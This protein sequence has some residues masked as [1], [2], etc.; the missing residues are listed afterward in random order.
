MTQAVLEKARKS[1]G[2]DQRVGTVFPLAY[3][4]ERLVQKDKGRLRSGRCR[5]QAPGLC[6]I[7]VEV[8]GGQ[9]SHGQAM[10]GHIQV[11]GV[12]VGALGG[13][14]RRRLFSCHG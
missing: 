8:L 10:A 4:T 5:G 7:G 13:H 9:P 2:G 14:G 6:R 3:R 11:I 1:V 12:A